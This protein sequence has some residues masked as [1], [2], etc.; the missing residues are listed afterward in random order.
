MWPRE[1]KAAGGV[2]NVSS[3]NTS[4]SSS[5]SGSVF[6]STTGSSST[7]N[8]KLRAFASSSSSTSA[9][10]NP[11]SGLLL[12]VLYWFWLSVRLLFAILL[13][14]GLGLTA[15]HGL[16][17]WSGDRRLSFSTLSI[18][19]AVEESVRL[20]THA[21]ALLSNDFVDEAASRI[22]S[23]EKL[24]PDD[25]ALPALRRRL[26]VLQWT[27][28]GNREQ[29]L[30]SLQV[31]LDADPD[32]KLALTAQAHVHAAAGD[33]ALSAQVNIR[34]TQL[35]PDLQEPWAHAGLGLIHAGKYAR[36]IEF[37]ERAVQLD[38]H[39]GV[40]W[41]NLGTANVERGYDYTAID[42][43]RTAI[44]NGQREAGV[45]MAAAHAMVR[46]G[47]EREEVAMLLRQAVDAEQDE[48]QQQQKQ[49]R[50][51]GVEGGREGDI[52]N[53]TGEIELR[54][55]LEV[56]WAT[57]WADS[58]PLDSNLQPRPEEAPSS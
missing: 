24:N 9:S 48:R 7:S 23:L 53:I 13:T 27:R 3:S 21:D 6:S 11:K 35:Q 4:E 45:V 57:L 56:G 22:D 33:Y 12:L 2:G 47:A 46:T 31:A 58:E 54:K 10:T 38:P 17:V 50:R 52:D 36:A 15:R 43:Y 18:D 19:D 28:S 20:R 39:D 1:R 55:A 14:V 37:L 40:A 32:D 30:A 42:C 29:A 34:L 26:G 8:K 44:K 25:D 16:D 5:Y 49:K 51:G 41:A